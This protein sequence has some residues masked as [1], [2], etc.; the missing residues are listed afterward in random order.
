MLYQSGVKIV[1]ATDTDYGSESTLRLGQE[2]EELV[3][4]G[5]S[6]L[7]VIQ[8]AT[9]RA[10]ELLQIDGHTGRIAEGL[11]ADLLI[12]ERN[13]LENVKA[14]YDPLMIINNGKIIINRLTWGEE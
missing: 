4:I 14:V 5:M 10:A 13:P 2:L 3:G 11:D 6:N 1:A 8:A 9:S 7:E 12:I